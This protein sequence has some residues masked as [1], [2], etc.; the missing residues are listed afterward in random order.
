MSVH[1]GVLENKAT[2]VLLEVA[3]RVGGLAVH[4]FATDSPAVRVSDRD[5]DSTDEHTYKAKHFLPQSCYH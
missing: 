5:F 4:Q 2:K 3:T 1:C